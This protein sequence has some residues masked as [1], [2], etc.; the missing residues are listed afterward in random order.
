MDMSREEFIKPY[1]V[2]L[3]KETRIK[4]DTELS[5]NELASLYELPRDPY[6]ESKAGTAISNKGWV[7]PEFSTLTADSRMRITFAGETSAEILRQQGSDPKRK[8]GIRPKAVTSDG[9][10]EGLGIPAS[11]RVVSLTDNQIEAV[12][13]QLNDLIEIVR[14]NNDDVDGD[15]FKPRILGQLRAGWELIRSGSV[16]VFLLE[17]ALLTALGELIARYK[18]GIIVNLATDLLKYLAI[19]IAA[20]S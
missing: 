11:D 12:E 1:I 13:P 14:G 19:V 16:R 17:Q 2:A 9:L 8:D 20:A 5:I 4:E 18:E 7:S 3:Y 6:F 15:A 10:P